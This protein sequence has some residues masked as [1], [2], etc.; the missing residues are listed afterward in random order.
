M[1]PENMVLHESYNFQNQSERLK[2]IGHNFSGNGYWHQFEKI[3]EP[4]VVW[5][6]CQDSDL[7]MIVKTKDDDNA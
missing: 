7:E 2:Y 4:C 1:K 5:C 6:E 3:S